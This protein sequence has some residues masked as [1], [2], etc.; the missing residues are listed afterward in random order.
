MT[1][2]P[3]EAAELERLEAARLKVGK[4]LLAGWLLMTAVLMLGLWSWDNVFVKGDGSD[5]VLITLAVALFIDIVTVVYAWF[6]AWKTQAGEWFAV[7]VGVSVF[8]L[9]LVALVFTGLFG[10]FLSLNFSESRP[11]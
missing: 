4:V 2:V 11:G 3:E 9:P 5:V 7:F 1:S 6:L 10:F 8:L